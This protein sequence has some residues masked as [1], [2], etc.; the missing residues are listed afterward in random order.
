ME[1]SANARLAFIGMWNFCDDGGNHPASAKRLKAEVFPTDALT[2]EFIYGCI[3][4]LIDQGLVRLYEADGKAYW[5]VTG[6]H[7]QRIDQP[8]YKF[9]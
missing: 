4:E 3:D 8:T 5:H 6:W 1:C 9:P 7:H 2:I